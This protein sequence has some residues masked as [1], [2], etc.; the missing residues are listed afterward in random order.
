MRRACEIATA[1]AASEGETPTLVESPV[2]VE[3]SAPARDPERRVGGSVGAY[4]MSSTLATTEGDARA[5]EHATAHDTCSD[6]APAPYRSKRDE[7]RTVSRRAFSASLGMAVLAAPFLGL[8]RGRTAVAAPATKA[9][10][11]VTFFTP[12]GTVPARWRPSGGETSFSFPAGSILEPIASWKDRLVIIDELDFKNANNHEGGMAA[13]L[14]GGP[15]ATGESAGKSIDQFLA[16]KIGGTRRLRSLELGVQTSAWGGGQQTRMSYAGP[17][18]FVPP[19]DSPRNVFDRVYGAAAPG[20]GDDA[21]AIAAKRR[22]QSVID[23]VRAD[24]GSLRGRLGTDE[25]RKLDLHVESIRELERSLGL[26]GSGEG[27]GAPSC[28]RGAPVADLPLYAN[29]NLPAIGTAQ[30]DLLVASLQCGVTNVAS[31]QWAHTVAPQVFT[32][33]QLAESHHALSHNSDFNATGVDNFV[34]AERWFAEQFGY[35]LGKL[36]ETPDPDGGMLLDSTMVLW[37]KEMGDSRDHVCTSVPMVIA[38][39]GFTTGRYLRT[40]GASHARMLLS[41][42]R[43]FGLDTQTFGDPANGS[44]PL[45]GL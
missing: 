2:S 23:A 35:L 4:E 8:L 5:S 10:R 20:N 21:A 25:A 27:G 19:D 24:L 37:C 36:A 42:C 31:I 40:G 3:K 34:K 43:A 13:M 38:G 45:A 7:R 33:L 39:A 30:M 1:R 11:F 28:D 6:V 18:Q 14:T 9:K 29:D 26:G 15:N 16:G 32:W 17:Q 22:K 44:V 41:I 12:N